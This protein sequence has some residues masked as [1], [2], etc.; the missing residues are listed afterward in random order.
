VTQGTV[1]IGG[2]GRCGSTL[3]AYLLGSHPDVRTA[4]EV[5]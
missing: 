2:H 1:L 4:G 5:M 3:L